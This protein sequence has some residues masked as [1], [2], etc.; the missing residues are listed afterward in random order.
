MSLNTLCIYYLVF[1]YSRVR[2]TQKITYI[3]IIINI[4]SFYD[5]VYKKNISNIFH[6][7]IEQN[8]ITGDIFTL[9]KKCL[10]FKY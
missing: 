7:Y 5:Q 4:T 3:Y 8:K 10:I 1:N 9:P 2:V 6:V